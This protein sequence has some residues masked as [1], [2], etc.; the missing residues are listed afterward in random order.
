MLVKITK[1]ICILVRHSQ[2]TCKLS[3]Y[4]SGIT[5]YDFN[6]RITS[7]VNNYMLLILIT[8][9]NKK[10]ITNKIFN[11][12]HRLKSSFFS[13]KQNALYFKDLH[14]L[15]N[16]VSCYQVSIF[17][18]MSIVVVLYCLLLYCVC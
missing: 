4:V 9:K 14:I 11:S 1:V 5:G 8:R 13:F 17:S 16:T 15:L 7:G 6:I 10:F 12:I 18:Y 3:F 2:M